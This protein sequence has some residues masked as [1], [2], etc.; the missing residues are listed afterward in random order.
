M[1]QGLAQTMKRA[2]SIEFNEEATAS[3]SSNAKRFAPNNNVIVIPPETNPNLN[4]DLASL[5]E[6]FP[7]TEPSYLSNQLQIFNYNLNVTI[8]HIFNNPGPQ[9]AAG[10]ART[11]NIIVN[12]K[13]T[14]HP[15]SDEE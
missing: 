10:S 3:A 15:E 14:P 5:I 1:E 9:R 11:N 8:D 4:P 12:S 13:Q 2:L 7:E 6:I